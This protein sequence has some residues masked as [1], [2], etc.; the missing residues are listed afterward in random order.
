VHYAEAIAAPCGIRERH[1]VRSAKRRRGKA[2]CRTI[3]RSTWRDRRHRTSAAQRARARGRCPVC[4]S[5]RGC[6]ISPPGHGRSSAARQRRI[7]GLNVQP[8]D[9]RQTSR[10]AAD[11]RREGGAEAL[12]NSLQ[13]IAHRKAGAL[14]ARRGEGGLDRS[15]ITATAASTPRCLRTRKVIG[16]VQRAASHLTSWCARQAGIC[17][18]N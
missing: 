1:G 13:I 16:A 12:S 11:L 10:P 5:E 2:R 6:R 7:V 15:A 9:R 17:R 8:F 4:G 18:A 14:W 3:I